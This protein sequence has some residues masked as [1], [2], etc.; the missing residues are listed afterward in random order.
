MEVSGRMSATSADSA[1]GAAA[2]RSVPADRPLDLPTKLFYGLGSV[3]FG[4]KDNGFSYLLLFFYSQVIGLPSTLVGLALL[5]ALLFDACIDPLIGQVS[6]NTRTPWG[7]RH[8]FMYVAALPVAISYAAIWNPP[9]WDHGALFIYLVVS[10][11]VIRTFTSFYEVPSSALAAEF[12]S[13]YDE[14]S[15]LL[16]YRYF[17]A[18]VGGLAVQVAA[19]AVLL[20]PD[21]THRVGQLNPVGYGHYGILAA[22][23][24]FC[25]ILI[26]T[27]GTH[28][29]IPTLMAPPPKRKLRLARTLA[30][31]AATL[32]NRSYLFLMVSG[33]VTA[34]AA[35]LGASLNNYFNT[36]F[37]GF[38]AHQI[39]F[40][41]GAVFLSAIAALNLAPN[42]SRRFGKRTTAMAL[43]VL[44]LSLSIGPLLLRV[45]GLM[46][47]NH[48]P[49]LLPII[50]C[51]SVVQ[52]T[53]SIT[54]A[55]MVAS[56]IADVVEASELKTGRRSEGLLFAASAFVS[57]SVSGFGIL[58]ASAV[59]GAIHLKAGSDPASVPPQV[60][61]HLAMIYAPTVAGLYAIA[62]LAMSGYRITRATHAETLR[63]LAAK[64]EEITGPA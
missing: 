23:V 27:A 40:L 58:G 45:A 28:S 6:D 62:L 55:T 33:L 20:T 3:A 35:G 4:V 37:W 19:F 21:R 39:S 1:Q 50:I 43:I 61:R 60:M 25:A 53:F 26:S 7:R 10:A 9:H 48:S 41:T 34:M 30:E 29:R 15:T 52:V 64:I 13:S 24:M 32:S 31:M 47:P 14:R 56:M 16:S 12:S 51:T 42:L 17:F 49:A 36:Y 2:A 63:Q 59:I 5:I 38:T 11:I 57:K 44:S 18:W 54:S 46:P 22:M 8:P